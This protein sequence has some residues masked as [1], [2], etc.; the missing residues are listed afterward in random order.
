MSK[1]YQR[2][3]SKPWLFAVDARV[4]QAKLIASLHPLQVHHHQKPI[5]EN[6]AKVVIENWFE[7]HT[8]NVIGPVA[9]SLNQLLVNVDCSKVGV[10]LLEVGVVGEEFL[11]V[12]VSGC[13][14]PVMDL[15]HTHL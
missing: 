4:R 2:F 6:N 14:V 8:C 10:P 5:W 11:H 7:V 15:H 3:S 12:V 9:E 1:P 13:S